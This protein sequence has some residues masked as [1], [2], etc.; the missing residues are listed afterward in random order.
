MPEET[1]NYGL[2]WQLEISQQSSSDW[3]F[4]ATS[5]ICL[6]ERIPEAERENYLPKGEIQK[7]KEDF[8]DCATRGPINILETKFNY[9]YRNG[10]LNDRA[11]RFLEDNKYVNEAGEIEFSD[12]F[13]AI[14]SGTTKNGNSMKAPLE[15]IRIYGLTPKTALPA[16]K[17]MTWDDYHKPDRITP[18]IEDLGLKFLKHFGI[19][20]ERVYESNL[21]RLLDR[22]IIDLAGYAWP[23]PI[24]GEYPKSD[25]QPNHV[26]VGLRKPRTYIFDNYLDEEVAGDFIKKLA[27]DYDFIDYGYRVIIS[28]KKIEEP[29]EKPEEV[30]K[31]WWQGFIE[32]IKKFFREL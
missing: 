9:L 23:K 26:F 14:L 13:I 7:G 22:D 25:E 18:E 5:P 1:K 6:A 21:D 16:E 30:K 32:M 11:V 2:D 27:P 20:Y 19:N 31:S 15:A 24:A 12:A 10:R 28:E 4:G 17:W 8:M 29:E 3:I